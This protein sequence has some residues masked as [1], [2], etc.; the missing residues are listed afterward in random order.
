MAKKKQR[1]GSATRDTPQENRQFE[2]NNS[3]GKTFENIAFVQFKYLF[4]FNQ[5]D[6]YF[7]RK[8]MCFSIICNENRNIY[9]L[10]MSSCLPVCRA[11]RSN[12]HAIQQAQSASGFETNDRAAFV[13]ATGTSEK[14]PFNIRRALDELHYS[15]RQAPN[16][17]D[18]I[19]RMFACVYFCISIFLLLC[20]FRQ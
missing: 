3:T 14:I 18:K 15:G 4:C 7:N 16:V 20:V 2:A 8:S 17:T 19:K 6:A 10:S 12:P 1:R 11:A 5:F 13:P 9:I